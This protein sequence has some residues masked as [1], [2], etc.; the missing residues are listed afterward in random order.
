MK[1][2][3]IVIVGGGA[4]GALVAAQ[5]LKVR[6]R[7]APDV[8]LIERGKRFG[9]GLAYGGVD[10]SHLLN[11]RASNMSAFPDAPEDFARWL[12]RHGRGEHKS[13]FA[14]RQ[15][16]GAYLE[17][18]LNR[19]A[20][21]A[22]GRMKR[23][24]ASVVACRRTDAGWDILQGD[25]KVVSAD[26]VVLAMGHGASIAPSLLDTSGVPVFDAWSPEAVRKA[27]R[28]GAVLLL[29]TGLT[30]VDLALTLSRDKHVGTIYALSRRGQ[31]PRSHL[32]N[33]APA[34]TA[35]LCLPGQLSEALH[36]FRREVRAVA[37]RGE[38]WQYA[39][40]RLRPHTVSL[41]QRLTP[42]QQ[43][44]FLRHLRVW[45]D[46]H[47]H[48]AAPEIAARV[49]ELRA[50][51]KLRILAGE[52]VAVQ[53][54]PRGAEVLH[55]QRGSYVRHRLEVVRVINCTGSSPDPSNASNPLLRQLLADGLARSHACGIGLDVDATGRVL[56]S[57]GAAHPTM[58]TIG[59]LTQGAFWESTAIPEIRVWAARLAEQLAAASK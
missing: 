4:S 27:P 7:R 40:D 58:F 29:G 3:R 2:R 25:G 19:A 34:P 9:P 41:W 37:A 24:R 53:R 33:M 21:G 48:R 55:R 54:T 18:T 42:Q 44:R 51:G 13:S 6:G 23:M 46:V 26:A 28:G 50:A 38:P 15:R 11:V 45:W 32:E 36:V 59:P 20:R 35:A 43:R 52:I 12:N 10:Q 14:P 49:A 17:E 30:M 56:D 22:W 57:A 8:V 47:R 1:R 39:L 31:I 16:Y 5:L